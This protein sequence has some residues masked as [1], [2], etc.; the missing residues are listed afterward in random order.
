MLPERRKT[1][2]RIVEKQLVCSECGR[3]LSR[4]RISVATVENTAPYA[5]EEIEDVL[6]VEDNGMRVETIVEEGPVC[7]RCAE[8][9]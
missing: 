5:D 4:Q 9:R 6:T 3:P 1:M 7:A 8:Y 2:P